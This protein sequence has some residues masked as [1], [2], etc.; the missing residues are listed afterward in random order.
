MKIKGYSP[1]A[2]EPNTIKFSELKMDKDFE[3]AMKH[4]NGNQNKYIW[5]LES[6]QFQ[7]SQELPFNMPYRE[8]IVLNAEN[9]TGTMQPSVKIDFNEHSS[10][11]QKKLNLSNL[12][13]SVEG[14]PKTLSVIEE[15][16]SEY[17]YHDDTISTAG[18]G[19]EDIIF[20]K[21][22]TFNIT[23]TEFPP[24][25][26]YNLITYHSLYNFLLLN[27]IPGNYLSMGI[28]NITLG[29]NNTPEREIYLNN[30]PQS[31]SSFITI[32]NK[33]VLTEESP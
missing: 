32:D 3:G 8:G 14:T 11:I 15:E 1:K 2:I 10:S 7:S 17:L 19:Y 21:Y 33:N 28:E 12:S 24:K 22:A 18:I 6:I 29:N 13:I 31:D 5:N 16:D 20:Q 30:S 27:T 9:I 25:V 4:L 23:D 26:Y